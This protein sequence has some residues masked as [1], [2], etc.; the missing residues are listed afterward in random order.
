MA[1][2]L[3]HWNR[4]LTNN[5]YDL[6]I[7]LE[8]DGPVFSYVWDEHKLVYSATWVDFEYF[9]NTKGEGFYF[10]HKEDGPVAGPFA[11]ITE[12]MTWYDRF[13]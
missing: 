1:A 5:D 4:S 6:E 3:H 13:C 11:T 8:K 10:V 2:Q 12:A 7:E 9:T